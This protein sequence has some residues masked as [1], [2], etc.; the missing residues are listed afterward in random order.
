MKLLRR[1][2]RLLD[3]VYRLT[4]NDYSIADYFRSKGMKVGRGCRLIIREVGSEPWLIEIGD[5][6]EITAG[7]RLLTH[8]GGVWVF[9]ERHPD[10]DVFGK[11][12]IRDN[13]FIGADSVILPG[14]TIGPNA[15]VGAGSVV[16]RDVPPGSVAAGNPARVITTLDKYEESSLR[17]GL[18]TKGLP[19]EEKRRAVLEA[20]AQRAAEPVPRD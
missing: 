15:V 16:T 14:V 4:R 6:V 17:N 8:D 9:R 7:V 18:R 12:V 5:H 10:L 13:C 3:L 11:I 1:V 19:R 2:S 20:L